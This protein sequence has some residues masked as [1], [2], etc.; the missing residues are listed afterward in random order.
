MVYT[1][2]D[3]L[4]QVMLEQRSLLMTHLWLTFSQGHDFEPAGTYK[5]FCSN[6]SYWNVDKDL[7]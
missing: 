3:F 4:R 6:L 5:L 2:H 1:S 7:S